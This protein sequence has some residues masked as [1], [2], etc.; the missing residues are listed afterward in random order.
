VPIVLRSIEGQ[1]DPQ[2]GVV[3]A[4]DPCFDEYRGRVDKVTGRAF[5]LFP[6]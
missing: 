3:R 6:G 4:G 2:L 5:A 1:S